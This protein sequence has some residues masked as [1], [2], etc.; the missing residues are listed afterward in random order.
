ME[1][2]ENFVFP[3]EDALEM[4]LVFDHTGEITYANGAALKKLEYENN[5]QGRNISEVFPN[6]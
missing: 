4:I 6:M 2:M 5:L 1:H 3:I